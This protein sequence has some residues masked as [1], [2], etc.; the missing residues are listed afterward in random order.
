MFF[1]KWSKKFKNPK[2]SQNHFEFL[3]HFCFQLKNK[4]KNKFLCFS[5]LGVCYSTRALQSRQ[6]LRKIIWNIFETSQK[7]TYLFL[8]LKKIK[9]E[10]RFH[11]KKMLSSQFSNIRSTQFDQSSPVQ[12]VS[13]FRGSST[14][15]TKDGRTD[16]G[17]P[18]V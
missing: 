1:F 11:R 14:S 17:N 6:I 10:K 5:I 3:K 8:N 9:E 16:E 2:K 12:P 4:T 7:L 13:D 18:R 15:V